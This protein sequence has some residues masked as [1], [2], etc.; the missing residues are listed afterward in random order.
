MGV[1]DE[2]GGDEGYM[3]LTLEIPESDAVFLDQFAAYRNALAKVQGKNLRRQWSRKRMAESLL[4]VQV[5]AARHQLA[6]M[7]AACGPFPAL[8]GDS[9]KDAE[10]ME[11]FARSVLKWDAKHG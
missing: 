2:R 5:D 11:K 9:K 6:E 8:T 3:R 7:F 1:T 10:A 4:A